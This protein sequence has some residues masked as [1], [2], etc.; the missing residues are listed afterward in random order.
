MLLSLLLC[1]SHWLLSISYTDI[2][3]LI[4]HKG[5]HCIAS[6][7]LRLIFRKKSA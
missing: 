2:F 6:V 5:C 3:L 1:E 7:V 4:S